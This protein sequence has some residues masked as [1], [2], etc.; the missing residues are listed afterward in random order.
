V[1]PRRALTLGAAGLLAVAAV[2]T[3]YAGTALA[4][5]PNVQI[6]LVTDSPS[7]APSVTVDPSATP[8]L[9]EV[10]GVLRPAIG[11]CATP[12]PSATPCDP[13]V[14]T[15][16]RPGVQEIPLCA[17]PSPIATPC[18]PGTL[19]KVRPAAPAP[20]PLCATP[21]ESFQGETAQPTTTPPPTA[22]NGRSSG[23]DG[24]SPLFLML[25]LALG[26]L[27]LAFV[28]TRRSPVRR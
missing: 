20:L 27:G 17:S 15:K 24:S 4:A 11:M 23:S 22:T 8:C 12:G 19:D 9:V 1:K 18:D 26:S 21:F 28:A 13:G 5:N 3:A 7:P 2:L 6:I 16:V 10:T 25:T 14:L